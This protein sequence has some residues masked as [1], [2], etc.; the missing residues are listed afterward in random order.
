MKFYQTF[1]VL[2]IIFYSTQIAAQPQKPIIIDEVVAVVG[3][4]SILF[5]EIEAQLVQY[6][7]QMGN[8]DISPEIRCQIIET[9][10][11]NK[12]MITQAQLDSLI[13]SDAQIEERI[14]RNMKYFISQFGSRSKLEE[15]YKK[16]IDQIKEELRDPVRDQL[17]VE[18]MQENITKSI[19]V[20]PSEIKKYLST[21]PKDSLPTIPSEYEFNEIVI[22]PIISQDQ[23]NYLKEKLNGFRE[24]ILKGESF[25]TLAVLYS[26]D[27]GSAIKGGE[28]GFVSRGELY[29]EFESV[30]FSLKPGEISSIIKS[31]AG[32]HIIQMIERRGEN[33]N[34][35]HILLQPQASTQELINSS[36]KLDSINNLIKQGVI[37]FKEAAKKYSDAPTKVNFG[38]MINPYTG[39]VRFDV[40]QIDPSISKS[41]ETM[42]IGDIS[43]ISAFRT[44]EGSQAF[45]IVQ[46]NFKTEPHIANLIDDYDK[47]QRVALENKKQKTLETWITTK[48]VD[49][50]VKLS[51]EYKDCKFQNKWYKN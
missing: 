2:A 51:D 20:T 48:L 40:N 21:I 23:V 35:R 10:L 13:I 49:I 14:E 27:K 25:A 4:K 24:R 44:E 22:I 39:S 31:K 28:L 45:R 30:A 7:I 1:I 18:M 47:I 17:T 37:S 43:A 15:Y 38:A 36:N 34:V 33:I 46:M 41:I 6:K 50:Y 42:K 16:N 3:N 29:P 11:L 5:S 19:T 26:E 8:S 9:L 12:L 32:Y